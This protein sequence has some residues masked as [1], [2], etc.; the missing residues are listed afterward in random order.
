MRAT[1]VGNIEEENR[2]DLGLDFFTVYPHTD[3]N[4]PLNRYNG[5]SGGGLW[6]LGYIPDETAVEGFRYEPMFFGVI[7]LQQREGPTGP[8][9]KVRCLGRRAVQ[10]LFDKYRR[11]KKMQ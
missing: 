2:P 10:S 4:S 9:T 1:P 6:E 3:Q 7:F 8:W 11:E 5:L